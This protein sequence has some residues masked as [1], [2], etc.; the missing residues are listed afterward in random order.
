MADDLELL[1]KQQAQMLDRLEK[2]EAR[3]GSD[4]RGTDAPP[5]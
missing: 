1:R 2:L 4:A 3:L 5:A